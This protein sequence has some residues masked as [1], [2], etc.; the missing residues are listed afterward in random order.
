MAVFLITDPGYPF[1]SAII[2]LGFLT[3]Q[4]IVFN[5]GYAGNTEKS[6]TSYFF[7]IYSAVL[8]DLCVIKTRIIGFFSVSNIG[9]TQFLQNQTGKTISSYSLNIF[10]RFYEHLSGIFTGIIE[11]IADTDIF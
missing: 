2:Q 7:S 5:S 11:Y 3:F 8:S 6:G 1:A 4:R 9:C 10:R